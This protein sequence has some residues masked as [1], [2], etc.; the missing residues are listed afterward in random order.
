[1][2]GTATPC[3]VDKTRVKTKTRKD[4]R[5]H[6]NPNKWEWNSH[7][8]G[9]HMSLLVFL[10]RVD[11]SH[12][13]EPFNYYMIP[14][15][16]HIPLQDSWQFEQDFGGWRCN[17]DG[18]LLGFRWFDASRVCASSCLGNGAVNYLSSTSCKKSHCLP[19]LLL[20]CVFSTILQV[21]CASAEV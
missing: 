18:V 17:K 5:K 12:C 3:V 6:P 7:I 20:N 11:R 9:Q 4:D 16:P 13:L 8:W 15:W 21:N 10:H 14:I 19:L 1:M 2:S